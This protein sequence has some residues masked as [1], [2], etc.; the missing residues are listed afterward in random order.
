MYNIHSGGIDFEIREV[1]DGVI[2]IRAGVGGKFRE[3]LLERYSLLDGGGDI[4]GTASDTTVSFGDIGVELDGTTVR[5][6]G[7]AR[8][9]NITVADYNGDGAYAGTLSDLISAMASAF[10]ASVM[11][12][13]TV[14]R[15]AERLHVWT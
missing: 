12:V 10:S 9:L 11:R 6:T 1:F 8:P 4:A 5:V 14:L 3:T 15:A 7:A 2:R 13:A